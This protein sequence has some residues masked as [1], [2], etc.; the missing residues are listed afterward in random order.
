MTAALGPAPLG[1]PLPRRIEE[2]ALDAW[3]AHEQRLLDGWVLRTAGGY[4]KRA[5]SATPLYGL[6]GSDAPDP[7]RWARQVAACERY[8]RPGRALARTDPRARGCG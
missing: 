6:D 5:N 1:A 7:A 3:P 4:T 2:A 8:L